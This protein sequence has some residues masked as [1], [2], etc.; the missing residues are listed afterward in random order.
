MAMAGVIVQTG[1][2]S[3]TLG[4]VP[5]TVW[6]KCF[7]LI[8]RMGVWQRSQIGRQLARSRPELRVEYDRVGPT[9]KA[10]DYTSASRLA[11]LTYWR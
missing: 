4:N 8:Y 10:E 3:V 11:G 9:S 5:E 6:D 7:D 2:Q 1:R